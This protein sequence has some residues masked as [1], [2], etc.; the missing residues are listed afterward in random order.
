MDYRNKERINKKSTMLSEQRKEG[1]WCN[2][3]VH[4]HTHTHI[5]T[6][7]RGTFPR[8]YEN[9]IKGDLT[10]LGGCVCENVCA[11]GRV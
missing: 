9:L 3:N 7:S 8:S 2:T 6:F 5:H 1:W 11:C 10:L 4:A